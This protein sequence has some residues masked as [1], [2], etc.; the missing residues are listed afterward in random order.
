MDGS[1][2]DILH[3][4]PQAINRNMH[5]L[6]F[7]I[8]TKPSTKRE[9]TLF[10]TEES[11]FQI[12]SEQKNPKCILKKTCLFYSVK[13]QLCTNMLL[14]HTDPHANIS[15]NFSHFRPETMPLVS[16]AL[17]NHA[18]AKP[19]VNHFP[20]KKNYFDTS[21]CNITEWPCACG[22]SVGVWPSFTGVYF[23]TDVYLPS[24]Y[25]NNN[26]CFPNCVVAQTRQTSFILGKYCCHIR[27]DAK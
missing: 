26:V 25:A 18:N 8:K 4:S 16:I 22:R 1:L 6:S 11:N 19:L 17:R 2:S 5:R 10:G 14:K 15:Q 24:V 23:S 7:G 12:P 21:I 27:D 20:H 9:S 13:G 3:S